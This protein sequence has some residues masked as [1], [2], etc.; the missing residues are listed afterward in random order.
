MAYEQREG[1]ISIFRNDKKTAP[2]Q[3]DMRGT[4]MVNGQ[5]MKISLWTKGEGDRRFLS[6][7]I[8]PDNYTPQHTGGTTYQP[9][10]A[11]RADDTILRQYGAAAFPEPKEPVDQDLPF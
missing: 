10:K 9:D 6:G 4:A 3:P 1:D 8:E 5:K 2:N 7:K 11:S